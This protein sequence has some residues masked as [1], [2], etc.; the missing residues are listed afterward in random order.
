MSY[1]FTQKLSIRQLAHDHQALV[2][3]KIGFVLPETGAFS[4]NHCTSFT[5]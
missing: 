2:D 1:I 4:S 5:S 3:R